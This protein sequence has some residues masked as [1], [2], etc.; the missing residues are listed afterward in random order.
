[1]KFVNNPISLEFKLNELNKIQVV[2]EKI[3]ETKNEIL[4]DYAGEF[5]MVR[6]LSIGDQFRERHIRV[7]NNTDYEH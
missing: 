6:K 1:M 7:G 4:G 5:E 3:H 2:D